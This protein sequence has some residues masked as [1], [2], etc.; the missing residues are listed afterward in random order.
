MI[1]RCQRQ[2]KPRGTPGTSSYSS[3]GFK[4]VDLSTG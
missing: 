3:G 1:G 4:L 2:K